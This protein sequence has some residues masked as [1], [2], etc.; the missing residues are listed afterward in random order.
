MML[1]KEQRAELADKL[2]SPW[3]Q[4]S[5]LCDG[6]RISLSVQRWSKTRIDFR[7]M[8]Y[9]DGEFK[10]A[11]IKGETPEA[12]YLRKSVR[13]MVSSAER[14]AAIKVLGK[15]YVEKTPYYNASFTYYHPDWPS[16]RAAIN[17]LCKVCESVEIAPP[18]QI[19]AA[20][21]SVADAVIER[22]VGTPATEKTI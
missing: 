16:G 9:V 2:L 11:W 17:H 5:L 1:T 13:P 6:R 12:K 14:K 4:V 21:E 3:G 20:L 8:T 15:R 10:G 18:N 7:V 22:I 19:E